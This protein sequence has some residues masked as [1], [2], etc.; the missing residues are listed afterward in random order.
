[1]IGPAL[2]GSL[3]TDAFAQLAC[4]RRGA[5]LRFRRSGRDGSAHGPLA[6]VGHDRA[7]DR[8]RAVM[9]PLAL[10]V[11]Q[12]WLDAMPAAQG[13]RRDRRA[14]RWSAALRLYSLF[15]LIDR[16]APPMRCSSTLLVPPVAIFL[17][18]CS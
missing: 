17:G 14:W 13:D 10:L 2:L 3:G 15:P 18:S 8:R 7:A 11:D 9:L 4:D 16:R 1:M 12:P 5:L 6:N